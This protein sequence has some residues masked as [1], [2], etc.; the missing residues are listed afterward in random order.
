MKEYN[1][2]ELIPQR[3]PIIMVDKLLDAKENTAISSFE[4]KENNIFVEDDIFNEAGIIENMAQTAAL[5]SGYKNK[6]N[7]TKPQT[8]F[9]GSVKNFKLYQYPKVNDIL[10]TKL[11]ITAEVF[12]ASVVYIK[13]FVDNK[14]YAEAELKI[15]LISDN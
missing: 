7:N 2:K 15:F 6:V 3:E 11:E 5:S 10:T 12:N 4:I 8:G 9:I 13:T 14:L 1:L